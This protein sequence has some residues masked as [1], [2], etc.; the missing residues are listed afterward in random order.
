M[1]YCYA[2]IY[3]PSEND[4]DSCII[5]TKHFA[6]IRIIASIFNLKVFFY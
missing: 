3:E 6:N 1:D 2:E 4:E 5:D